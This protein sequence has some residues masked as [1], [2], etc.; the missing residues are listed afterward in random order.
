MKY[1]LEIIEKK[2]KNYFCEIRGVIGM[3]KK[4][5]ITSMRKKLSIKKKEAIDLFDR[6]EWNIFCT[7]IMGSFKEGEF[8]LDP[9]QDENHKW[10]CRIKLINIDFKMNVSCAKSRY[11]IEFLIDGNS[12][13]DYE[14]N[15][16]TVHDKLVY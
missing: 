8:S 15:I 7:I 12:I 9:R 3:N 2:R 5:C 11:N 16:I 4:E 1:F 13:F 6:F 10:V 14:H